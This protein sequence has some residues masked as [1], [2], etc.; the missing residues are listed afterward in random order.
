[1]TV[2][3]SVAI[4]DLRLRGPVLAASGTFG[5][6]TEVPLLERRALGGHGLQ[7]HLSQAAQGHAA[8]ADRGDTLAACSTRSA[9]R[10]PAPMR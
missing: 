4:G 1:M 6:G 9:C 10:D 5:Y 8:A 2:D 3:L 7:G